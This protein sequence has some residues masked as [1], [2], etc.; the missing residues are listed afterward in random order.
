MRKR[1]NFAQ[2]KMSLPRVVAI[3]PSPSVRS[4]HGDP[5]RVQP[6]RQRPADSL[7]LGHCPAQEATCLAV[8]NTL[9]STP[10]SEMT[11]LSPVPLSARDRDGSSTAPTKRASAL[12]SLGQ[13]EDRADP[14]RVQALARSLQSLPQR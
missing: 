10:L 9:M 1:E 11:C 4:N 6:E 13:G 3:A 5:L 7:S 2:R 14:Y 8:G 12:Q